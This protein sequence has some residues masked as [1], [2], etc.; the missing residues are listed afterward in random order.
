MQWIERI[1]ETKTKVTDWGTARLEDLQK[2]QQQLGDDWD[3]KRQD[4]KVEIKN[5]RNTITEGIEGQRQALVDQGTKLRNRGEGA[6]ENGRTAFT[7]IEATVL[8]S[9]V[10]LL[11]RAQEPLGERAA[12]LKRGEEALSETLIALR[13]GHEATLAI[14]NFD[15]LSVKAVTAKLDGLDLSALRTLKAYEENNKGRKTLLRSLGQR[16]ELATAIETA[17]ETAT[18]A[19]A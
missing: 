6:L 8:E 15:S 13:A 1:E 5:R 3:S 11:R 18:V 7:Q 10:D 4:I 12:F 14:E 2:K 16:I 17:I 9:A 19:E